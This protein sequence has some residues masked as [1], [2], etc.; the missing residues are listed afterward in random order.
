MNTETRAFF[1]GHAARWDS[2]EKPEI[3]PVIEAIFD[4][5]GLFASD[6]VLDVGCGTGILVPHFEKRGVRDFRAIDLSPEMVKEYLKKFPARQVMA[7]DYEEKGLFP[8]CSFT[9]III[10]NAFPHFARRELVFENSYEYLKPGGGLYIV[11]SMSRSDLDRHHRQSGEE[12]AEH[13][14]YSNAGFHELYDGAGFKDVELDDNEKFFSCGFRPGS[15]K[16]PG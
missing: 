7:A 16:L 15:P 12:V 3:I 5:I 8:E 9:K 6:S 13:M 2:Y 10:F 14:L 4:R 1:D 11:H